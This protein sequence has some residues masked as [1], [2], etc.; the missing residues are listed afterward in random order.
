MSTNL[1]IIDGQVASPAS[2]DRDTL[3]RF[4][5]DARIDDVSQF[6][7]S[8]SG[9]AITLSGLLDRAAPTAE[10]THVTLHSDDG[11]SASLPIADVRDIGIVLFEQS[12]G[13]PLDSRSGG[14]YRFLIPNAAR[15]RTA[16]LDA[17]ANVKHLVR[18]EL[19]TG[20]GRDTRRN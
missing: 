17:C 5:A 13:E 9:K 20:A 14:P 4:P 18:I 16:D 1:L 12:D 2:L 3:N 10:A 7:R 19:T 15:C 6:E 11:F 8:R